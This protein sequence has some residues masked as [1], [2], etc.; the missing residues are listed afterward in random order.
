MVAGEQLLI[1]E[2]I[3][4]AADRLRRNMEIL[5]QRFDGNEALLL[6]EK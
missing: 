1:T 6:N 4:I 2:G 3:D 5:R